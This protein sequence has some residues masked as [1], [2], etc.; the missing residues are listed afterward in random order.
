MVDDDILL[1]LD[2]NLNKVKF[3]LYLCAQERLDHVL[4]ATFE[5]CAGKNNSLG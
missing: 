3:I 2:S 4:E 1:W 5:P